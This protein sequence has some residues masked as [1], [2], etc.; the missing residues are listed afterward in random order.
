MR[1]WDSAV[2]VAAVD[3]ERMP[4]RGDLTVRLEVAVWD[5]VGMMST[6][7]RSEDR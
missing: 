5:D 7:L 2:V 4:R 6:G 1:A 3:G